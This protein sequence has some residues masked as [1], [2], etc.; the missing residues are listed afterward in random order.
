MT[1]KAGWQH[2]SQSV[3]HPHHQLHHSAHHPASG[4]H[5][6][7]QSEQH[8][9]AAPTPEQARAKE[10]KIADQQQWDETTGSIRS[11]FKSLCNWTANTTR[12]GVNGI[13]TGW[14]SLTDNCTMAT[15]WFPGDNTR[16]H[17]QELELNARTQNKI[18]HD[19]LADRMLTRDLQFSICAFGLTDK[20]TAELLNELRA[21]HN[22]SRIM[23]CFLKLVRVSL[24]SGM[25]PR[26]MNLWLMSH[27]IQN[28]FAKVSATVSADQRK[29]LCR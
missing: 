29:T 9:P 28:C 13:R 19:Q 25:M 15:S 20:L 26:L 12:D 11:G 7:H 24:M 5:V 21:L 14:D 18:G 10:S 3:H 4:E 8:K 22:L 16:K 2:I 6:A 23:F 17:A 1:I 27:F